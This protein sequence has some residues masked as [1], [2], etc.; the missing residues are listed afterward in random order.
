VQNTDAHPT[1]AFEGEQRSAR[2][3]H[4]VSLGYD[5]TRIV[6]GTTLLAAGT[7]KAIGFAGSDLGVYAFSPV[8]LRIAVVELEWALG[9]WLISNLHPRLARYFALACFIGF[10]GVSLH[11]ALVG[12]TSCGCFGSLVTIKPWSTFF[13]DVGYVLGLILFPPPA[14]VVHPSVVSHLN[15]FIL[16]LTLMSWV[17]IPWAVMTAARADSVITID[18]EHWLGECCPL[19]AHIDVG[20]TLSKGQWL[21]VLYRQDCQA[22]QAE[23]PNY[24]L[25]ARSATNKNGRRTALI[26]VPPYGSPAKR[27]TSPD[28]PCVL[29]RLDNARMWSVKTPLEFRVEDCVVVRHPRG[30]AE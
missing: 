10:A 30:G 20:G 23:I 27:I 7:L 26:E 5:T 29:G 4:S 3:P 24:E 14:M 28:S 9:L 1:L 13:L 17:S 25:M 21:V 18:P 19:L 8:W 11:K 15:R 22:C 6:I 16:L 12:A 2:R